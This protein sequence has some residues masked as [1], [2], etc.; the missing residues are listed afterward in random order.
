MENITDF[1]WNEVLDLHMENTA[2]EYLK[3]AKRII[4]QKFIEN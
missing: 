4:L 2:Y 3:L 1:I